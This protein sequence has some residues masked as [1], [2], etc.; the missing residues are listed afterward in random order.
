MITAPS[1]LLTRPAEVAVMPLR[2]YGSVPYYARLARFSTVIID[3]R[4][5]FDKRDKA[6]HRF[7]IVDTH[8]P[9]RLTLPVSRPDIPRAT[10][11][12]IAV[13]SH[14]AWWGVQRV[15]LES[16]FGRTPF[17]EFYIDRFLPFLSH[18]TPSRFPLLWQLDGAIDAVI[19]RSLS[20]S[21][22]VLFLTP[23]TTDASAPEVTNFT[24]PAD[25]SLPSGAESWDSLLASAVQA[26]S[27]PVNPLPYWQVRADHHGFS[28]SL[29]I[30]DLLFNLGPESP[31]HLLSLQSPV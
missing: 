17:F 11:S 2:Y 13:S 5:R 7:D 15:S 3:C 20:L 25:V 6:T 8:G 27:I 12:S 26:S 28:P 4:C 14:G 10:L 19:R 31:L 21:T 9:L 23:G 29:S 18:S 30:L 1:P 16:A 22:R 24:D